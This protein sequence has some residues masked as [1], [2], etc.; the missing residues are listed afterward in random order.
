MIT[1]LSISWILQIKS[2]WTERELEL[3]VFEKRDLIEKWQ[4]FQR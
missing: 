3:F 1:K 2:N 4:I